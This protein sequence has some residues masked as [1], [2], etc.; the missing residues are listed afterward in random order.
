MDEIAVVADP[1]LVGAIDVTDQDASLGT[2]RFERLNSAP[3]LLLTACVVCGYTTARPT[4][5]INLAD[6]AEERFAVD[7]PGFLR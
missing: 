1:E 2:T 7:T 4:R 6:L 5:T 3:S